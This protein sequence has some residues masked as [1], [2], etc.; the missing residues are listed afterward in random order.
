MPGVDKKQLGELADMVRN[1]LPIPAEVFGTEL[2]R[3]AH[4][5]FEDWKSTEHL[6]EVSFEEWWF[7]FTGFLSRE[8]DDTMFT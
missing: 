1:G 3:L 2:L 8:V 4:A 6:P 7:R 5:F